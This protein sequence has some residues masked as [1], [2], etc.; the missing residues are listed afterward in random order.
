MKTTTTMNYLTTSYMAKGNTRQLP[1]A[2][3][4]RLLALLLLLVCTL[5]LWSQSDANLFPPKPEPAVYVHDYT[6]WLNPGQK[7]ALEQKLRAYWDSTSTQIV[8]M[9]RPDIGDY[10]KASYAFELGKRWG[11]G[12]QDKDNGV[13]VLVKSEPP[14]R[15]IFIATGYGVEGALPDITAGRIIRN[16]MAPYFKQQ[17]YYEG[18][19]AGVDDIIKAQDVG[20]AA[21]RK[22]AEDFVRKTCVTRNDDPQSAHTIA[23]MQRLHVN[24]LPAALA[25]TGYQRL[26][27]PS[28][29][30]TDQTLLSYGGRRFTWR[31]GELLWPQRYTHAVLEQFRTDM[32][33]AAFSAQFLQAPRLSDGMMVDLSRLHFVEEPPDRDRLRYVAI[34]LDP[35]VRDAPDCD[36]S[37]ISVFGFDGTRWHLMDVIERRLDYPDLKE[38]V[39]ACEL[40]WG[41]DA[42]I[43][44][45][46]H[47]GWA[48][49]RELANLGL[50]VWRQQPSGSKAERLNLALGALYSGEVVFPRGAQCTEILL[51]QFRSFP[52]GHDD[53][54]DSVTQFINWIPLAPFNRFIS[55]ATIF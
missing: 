20:S 26:N 40:E 45:N 53:V 32:G 51:D 23:I 12:R 5:P 1:Q 11:I 44:E 50:P 9:I 3:R 49:Y 37:A 33:E 16:T 31:T 46:G 21:R 41:A 48:L 42:V 35:A 54:L 28:I 8:V 30:D 13:V 15:G 14:E 19:N 52:D 2:K 34:S 38:A 4:Q 43:I 6:G 39:Q 25:E 55:R 17:Q 27:L 7:M 36:Y 10:D 18:I 24:D 29:A 22:A 47:T